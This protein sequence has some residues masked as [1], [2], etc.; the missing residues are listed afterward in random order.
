MSRSCWG[1]IPGSGECHLRAVELKVGILFPNLI[2][3]V[4]RQ[5]FGVEEHHHYRYV[6]VILSFALRVHLQYGS[7]ALLFLCAQHLHEGL[8]NEISAHIGRGCVC[9]LH[10]LRYHMNNLTVCKLFPKPIAG[11]NKKL[12]AFF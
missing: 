6:V 4:R 7:D 11:N 10:V 9:R 3:G 2:D 8:L 12:V 1:G 5:I